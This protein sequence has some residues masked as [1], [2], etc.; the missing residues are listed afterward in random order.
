MAFDSDIVI[1][2]GISRFPVCAISTMLCF[3]FNIMM[4]Q[5]IVQCV[6]EIKLLQEF[7]MYSCEIF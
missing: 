1:P 4:M 6:R 7:A 3:Y 5:C 2:G